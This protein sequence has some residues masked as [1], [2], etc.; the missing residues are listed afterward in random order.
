MRS[1]KVLLM[2]APT[3]AV[4]T[5]AATAAGAPPG[6]NYPWGQPGAAPPSLVGQCT[7]PAAWIPQDC[8]AHM[9]ALTTSY[10][11]AQPGTAP[12]VTEDAQ[13]SLAT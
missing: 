1:R 2:L 5:V 3:A 7:Q 8:S 12:V 10:R 4:L 6:A 9:P 11:W 13:P